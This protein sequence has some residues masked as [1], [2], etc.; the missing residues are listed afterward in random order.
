[1]KET[2]NM[3]FCL[4]CNK[5][6]ED[7]HNMTLMFKALISWTKKKYHPRNHHSSIVTLSRILII[8]FGRLHDRQKRHRFFFNKNIPWIY[9]RI[10]K[11]RKTNSTNRSHPICLIHFFVFLLFSTNLCSSLALGMNLEHSRF[12]NVASIQLRCVVCNFQAQFSH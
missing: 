12:W 11:T 5:I 2:L 1:M 6:S 10:I 3:I 4:W 9:F 7:I 8:R